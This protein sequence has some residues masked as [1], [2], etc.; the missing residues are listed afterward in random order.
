VSPPIAISLP[1]PLQAAY[2][3]D[4]PNRFAARVRLLSPDGPLVLA[5]LADPGRLRELLLPGAAV[6]VRPAGGPGRTTA[7][8]VVLVESPDGEPVPVDT[9]LAGRLV[10]EA[11]RLE[12]L[13][14]LAGWRL[15][16]AEVR[17][18]ASRIDYLLADAAG[19]HLAL[20]VKAVSLLRDGVAY[21]PDAVTARGRRHLLELAGR[22]DA[23]EAAAVLFVV[24][25]AGARAVRAAADIDPAFA[26]ALASARAAGVRLLARE[27][28][29]AGGELRLGAAVPVEPA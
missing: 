16:R 2:F 1:G 29:V 7:W 24:Q 6:R 3:V 12:A 15:D 26:F 11:L 8:S 4:R 5:H 22:A 27:A 19:R 10:R 25:R 14:E 28:L 9:S 21:F 20:E 23:G 17:I 13:D 18:G